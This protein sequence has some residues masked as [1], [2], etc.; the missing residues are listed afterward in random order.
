MHSFGPQTIGACEKALNAVLADLLGGTDLTE[1]QW[2]TL[3]I[4]DQNEAGES[5]VG[6]VAAQ[7]HYDGVDELVAG[8]RA[9]GLLHG[10]RLS[11]AGERL[12]EEV[13]ARIAATTAPIWA[14]FDER[15]LGVANRVL[16][17]VT[18]RANA[19]HAASS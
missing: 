1:P 14:G 3:R 17:T 8:L 4:A 15:D 19:V 10:D 2:V 9:R 16:R 6:L 5:L 13:Q 7:A 18:A 12:V 11:R